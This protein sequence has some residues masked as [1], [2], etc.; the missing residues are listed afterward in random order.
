MNMVRC[1][2]TLVMRDGI[3]RKKLHYLRE[4]RYAQIG[5]KWTVMGFLLQRNRMNH[6]YP[7][8]VKPINPEEGD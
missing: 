3:K 5:R 1:Q 6:I 8:F 7:D 2:K 4:K